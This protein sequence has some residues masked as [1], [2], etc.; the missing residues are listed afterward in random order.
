M[1]S[2]LS[3]STSESNLSR[4]NKLSFQA[5]IFCAEK[6][7]REVGW[8]PTVLR[9]SASTADVTMFQWYCGPEDV[10]RVSLSLSRLLFWTKIFFALSISRLLPCRVDSMFP[11]ALCNLGSSSCQIFKAMKK[12][13]KLK[14]LC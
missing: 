9:N 7:E 11:M 12:P 1:R 2:E 14:N 10:E 8:F 5:Q 6:F 3:T 13:L 4:P